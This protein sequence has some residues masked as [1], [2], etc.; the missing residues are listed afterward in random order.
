M[1]HNLDK[2]KVM[3]QIITLYMTF[4]TDLYNFHEMYLE[5]K[6]IHR[7]IQMFMLHI[8]SFLYSYSKCSVVIHNVKYSKYHHIHSLKVY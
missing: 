4:D 3:F 2:N 6:T 1:K 8:S 7:N 5:N